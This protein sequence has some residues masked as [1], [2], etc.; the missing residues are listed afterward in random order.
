MGACAG[1][2]HGRFPR[3]DSILTT[4]RRSSDGSTRSNRTTDRWRFA[5]LV[6][7]SSNR[8]RGTNPHAS[9]AWASRWAELAPGEEMAAREP[10][11]LYSETGEKGSALGVFETFSDRLRE[12]YQTEPSL[13]TQR[14]KRAAAERSCRPSSRLQRKRGAAPEAPRDAAAVG[15]SFPT[16]G[17]SPLFE[18]P[19]RT[20]I[21]RYRLSVGIAAVVLAVIGSFVSIARSPVAAADNPPRRHIVAG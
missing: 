2:L 12:T 8:D 7:P 6:S 13:E 16:S 1:A 21:A 3:R 4:R 11:S 17:A 18:S 9:L 19:S 5:A 10:M 14:I 15:A 20:R